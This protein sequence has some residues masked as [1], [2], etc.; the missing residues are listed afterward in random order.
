MKPTGTA[1]LIVC[2][3]VPT[4]AH[5]FAQDS[6]HTGQGQAVVTILSKHHTELAPN[7]S[8]QDLGVKVDGKDSNIT[9][10]TPLRGA[11]DRLELVVLID[12]SA[13]NLGRQFDEIKHFVQSLPP[14]TQVGIGYMENGRAALAGP[15]SSDH[16]KVI[17]NLHLPTGSSASPYFCLS[18]LAK[19]WPSSE[20]KA[21]REV[22]LVTDGVDPYNRRFDF[23]DSY[24]QAATND[25]VRAGLV[26]YTIYWN[27][28]NGADSSASE[29]STNGG[30]SLLMLVSQATGGKSYGFAMGNPVSFQPYLDDLALRLQNQYELSFDAP[31]DRKPAIESLKLKVNGFAAEVDSPQL[32]L[33][34]HAGAAE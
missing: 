33:V 8:Q 1:I 10:W 4:A 14:N 7:I 12:S 6:G 13:H 31:L 19:N 28:R 15:L 20:R 24:V 22:V 32:V 34:G 25:S 30:Q 9:G 2:L 3:A 23:D 21:R 26:V 5:V 29:N 11:E 27:G 18:D 17:E 16:A